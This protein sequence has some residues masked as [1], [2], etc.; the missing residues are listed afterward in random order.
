M[1]RTFVDETLLSLD[2]FKQH[3]NYLLRVIDLSLFDAK[4]A[5]IAKNAKIANLAVAAI[6]L[7]GEI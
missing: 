3:F 6:Y 1:P 2:N 7:K 4:I 5:K